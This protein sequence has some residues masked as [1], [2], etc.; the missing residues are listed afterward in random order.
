MPESEPIILTNTVEPKPTTSITNIKPM[1]KYIVYL[2]EFI[3]E[4]NVDSSIY[5]KTKNIFPNKLSGLTFTGENITNQIK[6]KFVGY[7]NIFGLNQLYKN[8]LY[9]LY[10]VNNVY[11]ITFIPF[12][13]S[14]EYFSVMNYIY[15]TPN[16]EYIGA[17]NI[18]NKT[19]LFIYENNDHRAREIFVDFKTK[20]LEVYS[21]RLVVI[22]INRYHTITSKNNIKNYL[23]SLANNYSLASHFKILSYKASDTSSITPVIRYFENI[24][25]VESLFGKLFTDDKYFSLNDWFDNLYKKDINHN[26]GLAKDA[27]RLISKN[28][29]IDKKINN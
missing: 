20:Y 7:Q 16:A 10:K 3:V 6:R 17:F 4:I 18:I 2:K 12:H 21:D 22:N 23:M 26:I 24:G 13:Y 28:T 11:T 19:I 27:V 5:E 14:L 9:L 1:K 8:P 15:N 29:D 25:S